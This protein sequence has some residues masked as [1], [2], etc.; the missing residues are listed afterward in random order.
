MNKYYSTMFISG[1]EAADFGT[2]GRRFWRPLHSAP[3]LLSILNA[4][5]FVSVAMAPKTKEIKAATGYELI[6]RFS[7][8]VGVKMATKVYKYDYKR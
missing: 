6:G 8:I 3:D 5:T 4:D 7:R 2:P 1:T